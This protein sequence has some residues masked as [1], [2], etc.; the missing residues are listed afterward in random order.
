MKIIIKSVLENKYQIY[1]FMNH[2]MIVL[3]IH[4]LKK[5]KNKKYKF[6]YQLNV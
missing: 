1:S 5:S 4:K 6:V 3:Y 2:K